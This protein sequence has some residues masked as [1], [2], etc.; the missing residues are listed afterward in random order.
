MSRTREFFRRIKSFFSVSTI[1]SIVKW[2]EP[3]SLGLAIMIGGPIAYNTYSEWKASQVIIPDFMYTLTE[4]VKALAPVGIYCA[5]Q[6]L[7]EV[8]STFSSKDKEL[9]TKLEDFSIDLPSIP[10][11][12]NYP[13]IAGVSASLAY[14]TFD[15]TNKVNK[16]LNTISDAIA[17]NLPETI[18]LGSLVYFTARNISL[19]P[20]KNRLKEFSFLAGGMTYHQLAKAMGE[21][22]LLG[23]AFGALLAIPATYLAGSLIIRPVSIRDAVR[24]LRKLL[25]IETETGSPAHV[26][27]T[28]TELREGRYDSV[29]FHIQN[30]IEDE[31][32]PHPAWNIITGPIL[33]YERL[34]YRLMAFLS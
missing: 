23:G 30:A 10:S 16:Q 26:M 28:F 27:N 33:A 20:L 34:E 9:P 7:V 32:D 4:I 19:K 13:L 17:S 25:R 15:A 31:E 21:T 1:D 22:G 12:R 18:L 11:R 14:S 8:L 5:S 24:G 2:R 29:F 3:I 6:V